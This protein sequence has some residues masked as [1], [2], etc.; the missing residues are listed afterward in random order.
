MT[1]FSLSDEDLRICGL[2][3]RHVARRAVAGATAAAAAMSVACIAVMGAETASGSLACVIMVVIA[4]AG[5]FALPL[6]SVRIEA[7]RRRRE[8]EAALATF[9]DIAN[10]LLAGGAGVETALLAGAEISDTWPFVSLRT[11]LQRASGRGGTFWDELGTLG[12]H[13]GCISL[14]EVANSVRLAGEHGARVRASLATKASS[15]RARRIA[16][17][18]HRAHEATEQMGVPMVLMFLAFVLLL[19]Y[20]AYVGTLGAL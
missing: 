14:V 9:L 13:I 8:M 20:P 12:S 15:L 2:D 18:E 16:E 10:V 1:A 5:A 6:R 11:A 4:G 7:G 17:T 3:A 19:G